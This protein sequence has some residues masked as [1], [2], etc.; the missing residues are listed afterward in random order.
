MNSLDNFMS[1]NKGVT[2]ALNAGD[3]NFILKERKKKIILDEE[4]KNNL[5]SK[6]YVQEYKDFINNNNNFIGRIISFNFEKCVVMSNDNL[7]IKSNGIPQ[8]SFLIASLPEFQNSQN[9]EHF[10]LLYVENINKLDDAQDNQLSLINILKGSNDFNGKKEKQSD[11]TSI[12]NIT[13]S[14]KHLGI[15]CKVLGMFYKNRENDKEFLF[16]SQIN[17]LLSAASYYVYKPNAELK[18]IIANN[19]IINKSFKDDDLNVYKLGSFCETESTIFTNDEDNPDFYL[20]INSLIAHRTGQFGKTRLGKSNNIKK[21]LSCIIE[22]NTKETNSSVNKKLGT[23]IFDVNGEYANVNQQDNTSLYEKYRKTKAIN[24]YTLDKRQYGNLMLNFYLN[25]SE[26]IKTFSYLFK[27]E[28]QQKQAPIYIEN[29]LNVD[30]LDINFVNYHISKNSNKY[31]FSNNDIKFKTQIFWALLK[32]ASY[33]YKDNKNAI[34]FDYYSKNVEEPF[35][36]PLDIINDLNSSQSVDKKE[37]KELMIQ[38][39]D[40]DEL[41]FS[42]MCQIIDMIAD[43]YIK[44]NELFKSKKYVKF[45]SL[46]EMFNINKKGGFKTLIRYK[47]YHSEK[48]DNN[49]DILISDVCEKGMVSIIDLS[50]TTSNEI[51]QFYASRLVNFIFKK[52]VEYFIDNKSHELPKVLFVFEE[53]H[54]L[55]P[56]EQNNK[57]IYYKLAKEGAKYGLG[58][59][60]STQSPS[61]IYSE[62]LNQTENFFIGHLS[63]PKE[64]S[65][66]SSLSYNFT[67]LNEEIMSVKKVGY[68]KILTTSHRYP[69]SVQIDKF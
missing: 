36:I 49:I 64:V 68:M 67:H 41:K 54:N 30:L 57:T 3:A 19:N 2:D 42:K 28:S 15:S 25:P 48:S 59:I 53:A 55:F 12:P 44:D 10:I 66:L 35:E 9:I 40:N 27:N 39:H 43:L 4:I 50:T 5:S 16:T 26:T 23:I 13:E 14:Q 1:S 31:D 62:L 24:T 6:D 65:F 20:D 11:E 21:I 33:K 51:N 61:T 45:E 69:I 34:F 37:L 32:K 63:S 22:Y 17:L 60:Y 58:M 38:K 47:D 29:F 56:T 7:I 46:I 18:N 8:S 52:E